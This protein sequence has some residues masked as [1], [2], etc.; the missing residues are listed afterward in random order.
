MSA[1]AG[2]FHASNGIYIAGAAGGVH[3][4][5]MHTAAGAGLLEKHRGRRY[6]ARCGCLCKTAYATQGGLGGDRWNALFTHMHWHLDAEVRV[7]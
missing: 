5:G 3:A 7:C 2:R 6:R 1:A 4:S